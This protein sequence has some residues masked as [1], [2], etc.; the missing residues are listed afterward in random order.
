[1]HNL[2]LILTL[3][4]GLT[5][6]LALGFVALRMKL[7]PIVGYL[8]A[9]LVLG[10]YTPGFV[11]NRGVAE[12]LA[13]LGVI[14]LMFGVGLHF[15]LKDLLAVRR[16]AV[17]GALVQIACATALGAAA[18]KHWLGW[19]WAA[20]VV[21]GIALSVAS[22][23]VLTRVL[24]EH[25][26][27]RSQTGRIAIGWLVMEDIF[28]VF[29]LVVL[30][31]VFAPHA[32]EV[33]LPVALGISAL[34]LVALTGL[35]LGA[36]KRLL[37]RLL[38]AAARTRSRELF[39][40]TVLV[41]ALGIAVGSARLFG[42]SM[43]LGAFLAGMV[44]GQSE[45]SHRA[46]SEALPLSD[47]FAV[48]FFVSVGMLF[49]P[50]HL[51]DEPGSTLLTTAI[52]LIAKPLAALSIVLILGY[53]LGVALRVSVAL[54]QI[55][56][57]SF[58]VAS[59]GGQLRILPPGA[60]DSLVAASMVSIT[61]NPLLYRLLAGI[62]TRLHRLPV[63][64]RRPPEGSRAEPDTVRPQRYAGSAVVVGYGP[65][66]Q[67]VSRLLQERGIE[68]TIIE[69]NLDT[70]RGLLKD[71]KRAV[72]GDATQPDIL[73]QAGLGD[74]KALIISPPA[75]PEA[76]EII[77][78]ARTVN[79]DIRVLVRSAFVSQARSMRRAGADEVFSGEA[80]VAM[81]MI[82]SLL[83]DLGSTP[84]EVND[85]RNRVR[86]D[87]YQTRNHEEA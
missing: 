55:G 52:V 77:R 65:V 53:G 43:A 9:G 70:V 59:L 11:A 40:L 31:A 61:L 10:P 38:T 35:I 20:G 16:I 22:T 62:E 73:K 28:T 30:P 72:Y 1:M 8:L 46:A 13:E 64:A 78:T 7:P 79:P 6:A 71:G 39:T 27:L 33:R 87:L 34:K 29:V 86:R 76:S 15:H 32:A 80:E 14:L 44:V 60:M 85:E 51:I 24:A 68:P 74:A 57:F 75:P 50:R 23:V 49:N 12:Q 84:N 47:A 36:G 25:G 48:L 66:G 41:I 37:P 81:A 69:L 26:D 19:S 45:F 18:A 2:D 5:A 4:A 83:Y 63:L 17:T 67:T 56:E 21:F 42:V 54:A 3:T 82:E 58:I